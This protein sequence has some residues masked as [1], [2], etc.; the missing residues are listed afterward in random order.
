MKKLIQGS[1]A[2]LRAEQKSIRGGDDSIGHE[3]G[4]DLLISDKCWFCPGTDDQYT[5]KRACDFGCTTAG[6][7][8]ESNCIA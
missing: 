3:V 4:D 2:I 1:Q 6:V 8:Y 7:C 5:T